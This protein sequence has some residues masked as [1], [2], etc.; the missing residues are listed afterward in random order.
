MRLLLSIIF[1]FSYFLGNSQDSKE[2]TWLL[3]GKEINIEQVFINPNNI[4][5]MKVEKLD[6]RGIVRLFSKKQIEFTTLEQI[7]SKKTELI[8]NPQ[9]MVF[10]VDGKLAKQPDN[11]LIDS[12]FYIKAIV[13]RMD[14]VEGVSD[15]FKDFIVIDIQLYKKKEDSIRLRGLNKIKE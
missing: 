2:I 13:N 14:E 6:G 12:F 5:S 11:V 4:D 8:Y 7:I 15:V 3:N 10:F 9:D 1:C